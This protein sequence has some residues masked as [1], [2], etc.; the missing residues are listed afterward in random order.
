MTAVAPRKALKSDP[1]APTIPQVFWRNPRVRL[2]RGGCPRRA[3]LA[4]EGGC[5]VA[6]GHP[7]PG[8]DV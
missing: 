3:G 5:L 1:L 8:Q 6:R 7:E 2:W 4:Q